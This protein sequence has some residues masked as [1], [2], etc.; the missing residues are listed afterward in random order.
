LTLSRPRRVP[1]EEDEDDDEVV[2]DYDGDDSGGSDSL[3]LNDDI[4]ETYETYEENDEDLDNMKYQSLKN[5]NKYPP[6]IPQAQKYNQDNSISRRLNE[7]A[8][9]QKQA[10]LL[11]QHQGLNK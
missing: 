8:R 10:L 4:D 7:L 9:P 5:K 3:F 6:N 2:G 1:V 11:G